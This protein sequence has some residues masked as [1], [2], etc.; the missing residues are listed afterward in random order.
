MKTETSLFPVFAWEEHYRIGIDN[1]DHQHRHL[2][3]LLNQLSGE[4]LQGNL[5]AAARQDYLQE[6]VEYT[7]YH[8]EDEERFMD[9]S[10]L[11]AGFIAQHKRDHQQFIRQIGM[12]AP[13][14]EHSTDEVMA[15]LLK[16]LFSWL[17]FHILGSDHAI[18]E[19]LVLI[20][21]GL[22]PQEAAIQVRNSHDLG[23]IG[24]L[25]HALES[26]YDLL[27]DRN[28]EVRE[29]NAT[30]ELRVAERT[31]ALDQANQTLVTLSQTDALTSLPNRRHALERLSLLWAEAQASGQPLSCL[32]IDADYFKEVNDNHGHAAG[33]LVLK[34]L[35]ATL[36]DRAR[37]DDVVAR[38]GGDEFCVLCPRTTLEGAQRLAAEL[39]A[40]V[41]AMKVA[42]GEGSYWRSS[43]SI[44]VAC[45]TP[46]LQQPD[47]LFRVA[48]EGLYAAKAAGRSCARSVQVH[49]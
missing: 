46:G 25:L 18:Q 19:Q 36:R 11:D 33:D 43:I 7:H 47:E 37:S 41:T 28:R 39:L 31:R 22:S 23:Q 30:L 5:N 24:P 26:F 2:V 15:V 44:G 49:G 16:F 9:D 13:E 3:D 12:F 8:F 21:E 34:A 35:A 42:T 27:A 4:L 38:L 40:T 45:S 20:N 1:I 29:V 14:I 32:M 6:L 17:I 48:D 10:G